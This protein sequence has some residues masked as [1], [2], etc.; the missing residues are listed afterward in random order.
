MPEGSCSSA[1]S[2]RAPFQTSQTKSDANSS[3]TCTLIY[4]FLVPPPSLPLCPS[5]TVRTKGWSPRPQKRERSTRHRARRWWRRRIARKKRAT[6]RTATVRR[7]Q[8][9]APRS[10]R[11]LLLQL[12]QPLLPL[13]PEN[14]LVVLVA[15]R[16]PHCT[17]PPPLFFVLLL[18][19]SKSPSS[20]SN[21]FIG[22]YRQADRRTEKERFTWCSCP[23]LTICI[24]FVLACLFPFFYP[25]GRP[26]WSRLGRGKRDCT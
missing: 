17:A 26:P 22:M 3:G 16:L 10:H 9:A 14:H 24:S 12:P 15:Y 21:R 1:R 8:L 6:L 25:D 2:S 20:L 7:R 5:L 18:F 23:D 13:R 11:T 4:I 19:L